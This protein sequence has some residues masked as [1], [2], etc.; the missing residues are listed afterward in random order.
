MNAHATTKHEAENQPQINTNLSR[1]LL[2]F[3]RTRRLR[4]AR[5]F[6]T[7]SLPASAAAECCRRLVLKACISVG[8]KLRSSIAGYARKSLK[9]R[10]S[11]HPTHAKFRAPIHE[12]NT[13]R[14]RTIF[15]KGNTLVTRFRP[16]SLAK[17][18][19]SR[20][21]EHNSLKI[22]L[23]ECRRRHTLRWAEHNSQVEWSLEA[24]EKRRR[25][26]I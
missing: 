7:I 16:G 13:N 5:F 21:V 19:L 15:P 3:L 2:G 12:E 20:T 8:K 11:K 18:G 10:I 6:S 17:S 4:N 23:R 25:H 14:P 24:L 22:R 9:T 1:L 26:T